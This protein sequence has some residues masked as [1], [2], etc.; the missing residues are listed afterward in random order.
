MGTTTDNNQELYAL[1]VVGLFSSFFTT[2]PVTTSLG[3]SM[4]NIECGVKT[5]FSSIFAFLLLLVIVLFLG[6]LLS[7]L[8]LVVLS[9]II[10][11]SLKGSFQ[12]IPSE[13]VRLW[14]V[15][16]IDLM[17]YVFAF[18][19]TVC[20]NVMEGLILSVLFELLT[21]LFRIQWPRWRILSK[22]TGTEEYQDCGRYARVT[23]IENIRIFR[24]D[25]PL[26]DIEAHPINHVVLDCSGITF[27]DLTSVNALADVY[28]R[29]HAKE[30]NIYFACVKA[31][32]R[33]MLDSCEFY[34][35]V[36]K[37]QFFPTI[38]DAVLCATLHIQT[39]QTLHENKESFVKEIFG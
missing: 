35:I 27:V 2:Y 1:G 5:Q 14:Q 26:N 17:I 3:R 30:I 28:Q 10:I 38:H 25:A 11:Y 13:L 29:M 33:D 7:T 16:K 31:T 32:V 39:K 15:S 6:P 19:S 36:P 18:V 20:I 8:P 4:L 24:F 37:S 12:K 21:T 34:K 22:L 9:A 23:T